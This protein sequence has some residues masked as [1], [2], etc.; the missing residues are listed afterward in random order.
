MEKPTKPKSSRGPKSGPKSGSKS[1]SRRS[2]SG[3]SIQQEL[4]SLPQVPTRTSTKVSPKAPSVAPSIASSNQ[5]FPEGILSESELSRNQPPSREDLNDHPHL[6]GEVP[7]HPLL[8]R[9]V[10]SS[11]QPEGRGSPTLEDGKRLHSSSEEGGNLGPSFENEALP[12]SDSD[13]SSVQYLGTEQ[14]AKDS[15]EE[16][17]AIPHGAS[18]EES[19][20]KVISEIPQASSPPG[21]NVA[22]FHGESA[23]PV[24]S[25]STENSP[26]SSKKKTKGAPGHL[27]VQHEGGEQKTKQPH[28]K[29]SDKASRHVKTADKKKAKA[30]KRERELDTGTIHTSGGGG[31]ARRSDT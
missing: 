14:S 28:L 7:N 23:M 15:A 5:D 31:I 25:N 1:G 27:L 30:E 9:E 4:V 22:N 10:P 6:D 3:R 16:A 20:G 11:S 21:E 19:S 29:A 2:K 18:A 12:S 24:K 17:S 26:S 8:N 13:S